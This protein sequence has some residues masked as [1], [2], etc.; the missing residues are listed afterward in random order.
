MRVKDD[1]VVKIDGEIPSARGLKPSGLVTIF[2]HQPSTIGATVLD[3]GI[4]IANTISC[5]HM[6][7]TN[8][9]KRMAAT[10]GA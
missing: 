1:T 10:K 5:H 4:P 2:L 3:P 8:A 6:A 7:V 9:A